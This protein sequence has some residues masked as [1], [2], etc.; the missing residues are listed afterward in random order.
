MYIFATIFLFEAI[1]KDNNFSSIVAKLEHH[2][3][4]LTS[5]HCCQCRPLTVIFSGCFMLFLTQRVLESGREAE[6]HSNLKISVA[7]YP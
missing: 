2:G 4:K 7:F 3:K 1:Q 5:R 6:E